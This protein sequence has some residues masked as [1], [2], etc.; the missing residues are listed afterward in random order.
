MKND[1]TPIRETLSEAA[2]ILQK[3]LGAAEVEDLRAFVESRLDDGKPTAMVY[4]IYNSG[5]STLLNALC[6]RE[7]A[8]VAS[9][10]ETD[11]I[12]PYVWEGTEILDTPGID[13]PQE[14]EWVSREALDRTDVILFV[15]DSSS[16]FEEAAVYDEIIG[17]LDRNKPLMIVV[18]NKDGLSRAD[19][20]YIRICDKIQEN[21]AAAA[22]R[23]GL[24]PDRASPPIRMADA[25]TGL[26]GRLANKLK[27]VYASGLADLE[28]DLKRMLGAAGFHDVVNTV[29]RRLLDDLDRA[30]VKAS[31]SNA[32]D[33]SA[34]R[35]ADGEAGLHGEKSRVESA[36]SQERLRAVA[37][38]RRRALAVFDSQ[39]PK[40]LLGGAKELL[41]AC[42][43]F[44]EAVRRA[45]ACEL[46]ATRKRFPELGP[47]PMDDSGAMGAAAEEIAAGAPR[48]DGA[49]DA[50][51]A[52]DTEP[53]VVRRLILGAV[54]AIAKFFPKTLGRFIPL[55]GPI[56]E[57]GVAGWRYYSNL[58][59][60]KEKKEA[61]QRAARLWANHI[62][63]SADR[64]N[65]K[66]KEIVRRSVD[67]AFA[68]AEADLRAKREQLDKEARAM[69]EDRTILNACRERMKRHLEAMPPA[70]RVA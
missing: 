18:N 67:D 37:Q 61:M 46:A 7:L 31:P 15:M 29:G 1:G 4:G 49:R 16:T 53:E 69:A 32:D 38:F 26:K 19:E 44:S 33:G 68:P 23:R 39:R 43:E 48:E 34:R 3:Y 60:E 10:P 63:E 21:L 11:R 24:P 56:V 8:R 59:R 65:D 47:P 50:D 66:A 45:I 22:A 30:L 13:A 41:G 35:I 70:P 51:G 40:E 27:L 25:R 2:S 58:Q 36:L 52:P 54:A 62:E 42:V 5:K 20:N 12:T 6:G 64:L 14:H 55:V 9:R 57:V 28:A 17:I